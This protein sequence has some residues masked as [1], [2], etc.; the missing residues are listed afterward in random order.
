MKYLLCFFIILLPINVFGDAGAWRWTDGSKRRAVEHIDFGQFVVSED[1]RL[2]YF[3]LA[4]VDG[5]K[6]YTTIKGD[7]TN[8]VIIPGRCDGTP[9]PKVEV[10]IKQKKKSRTGEVTW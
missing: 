3:V 4:C 5:V 6:V 8:S 2:A 7:N 1:T 10:E 9:E